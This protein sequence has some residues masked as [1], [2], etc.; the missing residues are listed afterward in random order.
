M[1]RLTA[2][3]LLAATVQPVTTEVLANA[4]V[5]EQTSKTAGG[6]AAPL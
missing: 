6:L 5:K 3:D 4:P 1:P 2:A